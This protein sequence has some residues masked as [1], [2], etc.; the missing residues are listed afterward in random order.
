MKNGG[1]DHRNLHIRSMRGLSLILAA[2]H[3][4]LGNVLGPELASVSSS[5]DLRISKSPQHTIQCRGESRLQWHLDIILRSSCR[6]SFR[7][8][9]R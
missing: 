4:K 8:T 6:I 7:G 2:F 9:K 1:C 5:K 3:V